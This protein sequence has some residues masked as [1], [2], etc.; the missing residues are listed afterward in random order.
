MCDTPTLIPNPNYGKNP[1]A[2]SVYS[3]KDVSHRFLKVPCGHCASCIALKQIYLVQRVRMEAIKNQ[4]FMCTL[5]YNNE[6]IPTI[7]TSTGYDIRYA[8]VKDVQNLIKR[9]RVHNLL[10][11]SFRTFSVSEFGS[12]KGRPHFHILFLV[13]KSECPT[14]SDCMNLQAKMWKVILSEWKRNVNKSRSRYAIYKPLCTYKEC[15]RRGKL[16]RNYDLHYLIPD[17]SNGVN[18]TAPAFYVLK[19]MLKPSTREVRLQQALKLNLPEDEYNS[20]WPLIRPRYFKS[21]DFG[22]SKDFE[23]KDYIKEGIKR[24]ITEGSSFAFFYNPDDG[25]SWPLSRFYRNKGDLYS[26]DDALAFKN[27]SD[28]SREDLSSYGDEP[29]NLDQVFKRFADYERNCARTDY[30][31]FDFMYE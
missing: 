25:T 10:G 15:Y 21:L 16:Y 2:G 4:L 24:S 6:M 18:L 14:F 7:T 1:I 8:D 22:L 9:L 3:V 28:E 17:L 29:A 31:C 5:T 27:N 20:I 11:V 12:K 23:I 26:L 30:D 13:P 19:Y